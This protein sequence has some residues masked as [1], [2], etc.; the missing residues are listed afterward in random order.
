MVLHD[1][2]LI[3]G[4]IPGSNEVTNLWFDFMILG[5]GPF[6]RFLEQDWVRMFNEVI[7]IAGRKPLELELQTVVSTGGLLQIEHPERYEFVRIMEKAASL[8]DYPNICTHV[9]NPTFWDR[10][11]GPFPHQVRSMCKR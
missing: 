1:I 2:K 7:R 6:P 11:L 3:L 8:R 9:W 4:T 5:W 10:A